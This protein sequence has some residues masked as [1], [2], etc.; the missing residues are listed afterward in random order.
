MS[1]EKISY[2]GENDIENEFFVLLQTLILPITMTDKLNQVCLPFF[3]GILD[4]NLTSAIFTKDLILIIKRWIKRSLLQYYD[5]IK[6][7]KTSVR[8]LNALDQIQVLNFMYVG[9]IFH[10]EII[11]NVAFVSFEE[12]FGTEG[13]LYPVLTIIGLSE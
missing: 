3:A 13:S 6:C 2:M 10:H 8:N 1:D 4:I 9:L 7:C 5:M 11:G 12:P